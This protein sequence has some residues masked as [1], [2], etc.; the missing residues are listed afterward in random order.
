MGRYLRRDFEDIFTERLV[1]GVPVEVCGTCLLGRE[2]WRRTLPR[3]SG[4]AAGVETINSTRQ[5][6]SM[7]ALIRRAIVECSESV[8]FNRWHAL[9]VPKVQ[10]SPQRA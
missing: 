2:G 3:L 5:G 10:P 1:A 8:G 4:E 6:R 9:D 7:P